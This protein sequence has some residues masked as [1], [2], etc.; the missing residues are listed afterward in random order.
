[1]FWYLWVQP[2]FWSPTFGQWNLV[3]LSSVWVCVS[4]KEIC[5]STAC[6]HRHLKVLS[7]SAIPITLF[8]VMTSLTAT[9]GLRCHLLFV[10]LFSGC[11]ALPGFPLVTFRWVLTFPSCYWYLP[12]FLSDFSEHI[13][14]QS[15]DISLLMSGMKQ[16]PPGPCCS[17]C[18]VLA[19]PEAYS[20]SGS[21]V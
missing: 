19:S 10:M 17:N 6:P 20:E 8:M 21:A 1:M 4:V 18:G 3:L 13:C 14:S 2:C 11:Q 9:A 5:Y 7:F 12:L 15:L 16:S